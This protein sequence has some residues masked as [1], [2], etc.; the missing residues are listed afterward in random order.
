MNSYFLIFIGI[1]LALALGYLLGIFLHGG[2]PRRAMQSMLLIDELR[3]H[4]GATVEIACDNPEPETKQDQV[5]VSVTDDWTDWEPR[6]FDGETVLDCLQKA[7]FQRDCSAT[8]ETVMT[9][10]GK[11]RVPAHFTDNCSHEDCPH[12]H[13]CLYA[14]RC[15]NPKA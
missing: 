11:E 5:W 14:K 13:D 12:Y 8:I 2:W 15:L 10:Q 4:E 6:R 9:A 1:V 7:K 3:A